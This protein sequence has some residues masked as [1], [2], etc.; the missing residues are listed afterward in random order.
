[1]DKIAKKR[2]KIF[3]KFYNLKKNDCVNMLWTFQVY[4]SLNVMLMN[5]NKKKQNQYIGKL[6]HVNT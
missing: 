2:V 3:K 1:M 6:C 4:L 5:L